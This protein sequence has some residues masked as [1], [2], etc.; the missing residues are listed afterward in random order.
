MIFFN[1]ISM[2]NKGKFVFLRNLTV[3][4]I[5]KAIWKDYLQN[6]NFFFLIMMFMTSQ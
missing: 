3:H 4:L 6:N 5:T 1:S 2:K